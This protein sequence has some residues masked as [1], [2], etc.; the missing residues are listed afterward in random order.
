MIGVGR[1]VL[2][3]AILSSFALA[4]L[5]NTTDTDDCPTCCKGDTDGSKVCI[6]DILK[7]PLNPNADFGVLVTI[8]IIIA[9]FVIGNKKDN[10]EEKDD[11]LN[12]LRIKRIELQINIRL[13]NNETF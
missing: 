11:C 2:S 10:E 5:C 7:C 8:L 3:V 9:S 4:D 1:I 13:Q 12:L 6:T